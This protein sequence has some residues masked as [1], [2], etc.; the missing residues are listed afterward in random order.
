MSI[1]KNFGLLW[2]RDHLGNDL[3]GYWRKDRSIVVDFKKQ[4]GIYILY[5]KNHEAVYVGQAGSKYGLYQRINVHC[6]DSKWLR[7]EYFSWFGFLDR[8]QETGQLV[9]SK[10]Y[11]PKYEYSSAL[12]DIEGLLIKVVEPSLNKKGCTFDGAEEYRQCVQETEPDDPSTTLL[13]LTEKVDR[14]EEKIN[15]LIENKS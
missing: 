8:D 3:L 7:W 2:N 6:K 10:G 15:K 5:N 13:K 9:K 1:I 11:L 12:T 4:I 14:L